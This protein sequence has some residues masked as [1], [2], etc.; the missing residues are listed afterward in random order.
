M[1]KKQSKFKSSREK[2]NNKIKLQIKMNF[3]LETL[4]K[5]KF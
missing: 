4:H 5:L 3:Q 1:K 2:T